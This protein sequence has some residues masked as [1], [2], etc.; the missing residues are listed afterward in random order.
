MRSCTA[1]GRVAG[2]P[3]GSASLSGS[4]A[5]I[6]AIKTRVVS[7]RYR[8]PFQISSGIS[9]ELI[10]LV[11]EVHTADGAIGIGETSPMTAYTGETLAGVT[12]RDRGASR[13]G[14]D[15]P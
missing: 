7:A 6:S 9:T 12:G 10:S 11:V 4:S 1:S 5:P 2:S 3:A 14:A 8:R 13:A 15:R